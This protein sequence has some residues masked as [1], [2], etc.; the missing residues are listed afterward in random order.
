MN[1]EIDPNS[2]FCFGVKR[3]IEM[4]EVELK[5]T[6]KLFCI[7][8]IVHNQLEVERLS[9]KGLIFVG[10]E[11]FKNLKNCKVLIRAHGE[12]PR[13]YKIARENNIQLI[14]ATCPIVLNLQ[15]K[16]SACHSKMEEHDG[17]VLIYGKKGHAEVVG[18]EGMANNEAI[19]ISDAKDIEKI[20]FSRPSC[21]FSQTTKSQHKY[22]ALKKEIMK[23]YH[24]KNGHAP[25]F[26]AYNTICNKVAK[27]EKELKA[28]V[29]KHELILFVSGK[30][31]SNGKFLYNVCK[32]VNPQ[33]LFIS[34]V[35]DLPES[36][37]AQ[38]D[39]GICGATSTPR[40]LMK[41]VAS[42]VKEIAVS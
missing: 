1:I 33:T 9:K 37:P 13:T 10:H 31:S 5:G 18:L 14:D 17:Q 35:D 38:Q 39:I 23:R 32:S 28:F 8:E 20:N 3:A 24:K 19:V 7:G 6:S 22:E 27:R 29:S 34:S 15:E 12:P 11:Q 25:E 36:I 2:G 42:K 16:I 30:N 40:W 21:L 4:A 41:K 26:I